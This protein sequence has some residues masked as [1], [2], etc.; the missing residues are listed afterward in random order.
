MFRE[1]FDSLYLNNGFTLRRNYI[2]SDL[3]DKLLSLTSGLNTSGYYPNTKAHSYLDQHSD[4]SLLGDDLFSHYSTSPGFNGKRSDE[5]RILRVTSPGDSSEA[6]RFHFDSHCA[7]LVIGLQV[8][9]NQ[10]GGLLTW[11]L[12]RALPTNIFSDAFGKLSRYHKLPNFIKFRGLS[13]SLDLSLGSGDVVLFEGYTCFHG[14]ELLS[15]NTSMPRKVLIIHFF[16]YFG[17]HSLG[18]LVRNIRSK[19]TR[20]SSN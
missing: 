8:D 13:D 17:G 4:L 11:P 7:T 19:I 5:Y 9:L 10:G 2:D 1:L 15:P 6:G 12:S 3:V 20:K 16:D 14:N 18:G